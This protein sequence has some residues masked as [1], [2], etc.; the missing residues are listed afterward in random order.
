MTIP[1]LIGMNITTSIHKL[2]PFTDK[3][4]IMIKRT[5]SPFNKN[6]NTSNE[7]RVI[8]QKVFENNIELIISYF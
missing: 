7:C 1:N 8:R 6:L 4:N 5:K 2:I 3:Y